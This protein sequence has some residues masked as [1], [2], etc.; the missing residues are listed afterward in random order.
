MV[1]GINMS[2]LKKALSENRHEIADE[3]GL[4]RDRGCVEPGKVRNA[5]TDPDSPLESRT[6]RKVRASDEDDNPKK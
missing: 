6:G 3:L 5:N 4:N 2:K 1:K